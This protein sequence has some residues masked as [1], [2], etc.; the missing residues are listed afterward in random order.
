MERLADRA[1]RR[2]AREQLKVRFAHGGDEPAHPSAS[3]VLGERNRA[4]TDTTKPEPS[5]FNGSPLTSLTPPEREA[6]EL[7]RREAEL[8]DANRREGS[9]GIVFIGIDDFDETIPAS[10]RARRLPGDEGETLITADGAPLPAR[11]PVP[12]SRTRKR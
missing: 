4:P 12:Q 3:H 5:L 1:R 6:H 2:K 8:Q 7:L 11:H 9:K 10:E